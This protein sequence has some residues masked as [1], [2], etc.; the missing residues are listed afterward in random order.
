MSLRQHHQTQPN[1]NFLSEGVYFGHYFA[2]RCWFLIGE[3]SGF[4]SPRGRDEVVGIDDVA[5][6]SSVIKALRSSSNSNRH[7]KQ[8]A[9]RDDHLISDIDHFNKIV[10]DRSQEVSKAHAKEQQINEVLANYIPP[11]QPMVIL[12][13]PTERKNRQVPFIP[14]LHNHHQSYE[15]THA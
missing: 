12:N 8:N 5:V 1:S 13:S 10:I 15:A 14:F 6:A 4:N 11:P 3:M 2:L 9:S 7:Y